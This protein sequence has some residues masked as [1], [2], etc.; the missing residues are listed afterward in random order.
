[1]LGVTPNHI[2]APVIFCQYKYVTYYSLVKY[3]DSKENATLWIR[4]DSST[5]GQL[6]FAD[7]KIDGKLYKI[8]QIENESKYDR[9]A[10]LEPNLWRAW[11]SSFYALTAEDIT[12]I[13]K[14]KDVELTCYL[15]NG[16]NISYK[17]S[18]ERLEEWK[19]LLKLTKA[20]FSKTKPN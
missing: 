12:A 11:C 14:G 5:W 2:M 15:K 19:Q 20:D 16:K 8:R 18:P 13:E 3:I 10:Y 17:L 7:L 1:M 6:E 9:N 4:S